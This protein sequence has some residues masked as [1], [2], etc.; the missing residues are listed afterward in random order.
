M[1]A[2]K[3]TEPAQRSRAAKPVA[4]ARHDA[5]RR[6]GLVESSAF[7]RFH[8]VSDACDDFALSRLTFRFL[9]QSHEKTNR[10]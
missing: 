8:A 10:K 6:T 9:G 7:G 3:T 5:I 4:F 2:A 1:L